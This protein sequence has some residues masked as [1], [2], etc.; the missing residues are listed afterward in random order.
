M[1][2]VF[3]CLFFFVL[4]LHTEGVLYICGCGQ[5]C[6]AVEKL[7]LNLLLNYCIA[8]QYL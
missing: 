2:F 6:V 3:V 4:L 7:P 8:N 1:A 5:I